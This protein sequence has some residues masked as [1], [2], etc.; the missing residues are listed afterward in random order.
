MEKSNFYKTFLVLA[1]PMALQ[2][3][4]TTGVNLIDN[5][6]IGQLGDVPIASVGLANKIFFLYSLMIFGMCGGASAFVTQY[7]GK[8]DYKGIKNAISINMVVAFFISAVFFI[9]TLIAPEFLMSLL[10]DDIRVIKTGAEYLKIISPGFIFTGLTLV[11]SYSLKNLEHPKIPLAGSV[12]SIL[13]NTV[14]NYILIFG[15]FGLPVLE[16]RGAAIA[17]TIARTV[18]FIFIFSFTFK[19][20]DFLFRDFKDYLKIPG[21]F[22]RSFFKTALPVTF[23]ETLWSLGTTFMAA[24]YARISTEVIASV[25]IV[26]IMY[27]LSSIFLFGASHATGIMIGKEIGLK[28]YENAYDYGKR[29]AILVPAVSGVLGIIL[30]ILCPQFLKLFNISDSVRSLTLMLYTVMAIYIPVRAFN[31]VNIVGTLR[32]GG[33]VVYCLVSDIGCIWTI[34][35]LGSYLTGIVFSLPIL[36]VYIISQGEEAVK[37]IFIYKRLSKRNWIKDLVN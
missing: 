36:L 25:N 12:I 10:S 26:N 6:M 1:L 37:S 27:D 28:R 32:S 19:K 11:C 3:M 23:N 17:T 24:I 7:W 35:V 20:L 13:I 22:M 15:K 31:T 18:E 14:L 2:N 29:L 9:L 33:D 30:L 4:L 21:T 5:I 8:K 34:G 16:T